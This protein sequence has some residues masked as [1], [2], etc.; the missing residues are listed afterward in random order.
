[1][2]AFSFTVPLT[3]IAVGGGNGGGLD[4]LVVGSGRAV[5]AAALAAVALACTRSAL[6]TVRQWLRLVPVSVGVV[7]GF[8]ILTSLA[9]R[10]TDSGH[11]AVVIGML[12]ATTAVAAVLMV[13]ERP[14]RRFWVGAGCGVVATAVFSV[15]AYGSVAAPGIADV[16]LFGAVALAAV[17]YAQG[18]RMARELGAWQT[19]SWALLLALPAMAILSAWSVSVHPPSA[20]PGQWAAFGYLCAV[21]MYLGFFAWYR[22][23]AIGPM[24]TVSQVQLV[25]PVLSVIWGVLLL[26]ERLSAPLVVGAIGVIGCAAFTVRSRSRIAHRPGTGDQ[27]RRRDRGAE[28][29]H[30]RHTR[31]ASNRSTLNVH[32]DS[33]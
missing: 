11:A 2:L 26:G 19:V 15:A 24:T 1:M 22:G 25:Q 9:L 4:P 33:G 32:I 7:A 5:V 21:S 13:G 27:V 18:G 8:P 28:S 17:G 10:H 23:L 30:G 20:S 14:G 12:P 6:P 16:Y 3:R 31:S 29:P